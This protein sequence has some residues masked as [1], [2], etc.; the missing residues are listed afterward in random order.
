MPLSWYNWVNDRSIALCDCA[1]FSP[2]QQEMACSWSFH[3]VTAVYFLLPPAFFLTLTRTQSPNYAEVQIS[4]SSVM[5][6]WWLLFLAIIYYHIDFW[7]LK[8]TS[9]PFMSKLVCI[10]HCI[11]MNIQKVRKMGSVLFAMLRIWA[12]EFS[13]C[14]PKFKWNRHLTAVPSWP[15]Q[16]QSE[17]THPA[18][19]SFV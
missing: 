5:G 16:P 19:P 3:Q 10:F 8:A 6:I 17:Q 9:C 14:W 18:Q 12:A 2:L 11:F 7:H 13:R 1:P 15:I 4:V